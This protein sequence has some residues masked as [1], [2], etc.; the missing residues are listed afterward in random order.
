MNAQMASNR[1]APHVSSCMKF[2]GSRR[3]TARNSNK[4]R[5]VLCRRRVLGAWLRVANSRL[6]SEAGR[7]DSP[8]LASENG[9]VSDEGKSPS[10]SKAKSKAKRDGEHHR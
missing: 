1:F 10:K 9:H 3:G 6:P 4:N 5:C 8:Y 2:G 7:S